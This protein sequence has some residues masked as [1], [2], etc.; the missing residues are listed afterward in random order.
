MKLEEFRNMT[1]EE[2]DDARRNGTLILDEKELLS[3]SES[4]LFE[5]FARVMEIEN[6]EGF[7]NGQYEAVTAILKGKECFCIMPTGSGK[8]ECFQF[9]ALVREGITVVIE[10]IIALMD[11]QIRRIGKSATRLSNIPT[12]EKDIQKL[13]SGCKF[14]Y[15]SPETLLTPKFIMLAEQLNI[16]ML[17]VD[18]AHCVSL[19]GNG[20]R[21]KFMMISRAFRQLKH[22]PQVVAFTATATEFVKDQVK[23]VLSMRKDRVFELNSSSDPKKPFKRDNIELC[24]KSIPKLKYED[25]LERHLGI[26]EENPHFTVI[27]FLKCHPELGKLFSA[28]KHIF[29]TFEAPTP[30]RESFTTGNDDYDKLIREWSRELNP[31]KAK[32]QRDK[33]LRDKR[34]EVRKLLIEIKMN[35]KYPFLL[36]DIL[37]ADS[38]AK[39]IGSDKPAAVIVYCSTIA[40]TNKL[41][42]RLRTDP[43]IK[44]AK[45]TPCIYHGM[46]EHEQRKREQKYF[47]EDDRCRLMVATKA[48]GIGVDKGNVRLVVHFGIPRCIE[49]Y[50]QEAGRGGRDRLPS[51]AVLYDYEPDIEDM[52]DAILNEIIEERPTDR[53]SFDK[54]K[55]FAD[56]MTEAERK[57]IR[58]LIEWRKK[59]SKKFR[60]KKSAAEM[61]VSRALALYG[62]K[63]SRLLN[64]IN[65][66]RY[67]KLVSYLFFGGNTPEERREYIA[68]YLAYDRLDLD[69][70]QIEDTNKRIR[71][72]AKWPEGLTICT[73]KAAYELRDGDYEPGLPHICKEGSGGESVFFISERVDFLD[74]MIANAVFSLGFGG[75]TSI[76]VKKIFILLTGDPGAA[77]EPD[78][79]KALIERIKRLMNVKMDISAG[80]VSVYGSFLELEQKSDTIF[81]YLGPGALCGFSQ[82]YKQQFITIPFEELRTGFTATA[83]DGSERSVKTVGDSFDNIK[84]KLMLAWRLH[85]IAPDPNKQRSYNQNVIRIISNDKRRKGLIELLDLSPG[86]RFQDILHRI[87]NH[88]VRLG[89]L[90]PD[91]E[92][93]EEHIK[94]RSAQLKT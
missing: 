51:R 42:N 14:I 76:T 30:M 44:A 54:L 15:I 56:R 74:I 59:T 50:F 40:E 89:L 64:A 85:M 73:C 27:K 39:S 45:I 61:T 55:S 67:K 84:L 80:E 68:H 4:E 81:N 7:N 26:T 2:V 20:F 31:A 17:V 16:R 53:M 32:F 49:D 13:K 24:V 93:T 11:D 65:Y 87:L 46:M 86:P 70:K 3:L 25:A 79:R 19:W 66:V 62:L 47:M 9:P 10:P 75:M 72:E 58:E 60:A 18:E 8:S 1:D 22:R 94:W 12:L 83:A 92:L 52:G 63:D 57:A 28:Y 48:F 29:I 82:K 91:Y 90:E 23:T 35:E 5:V 71:H 88:Y 33:A 41:Y 6:G 34:E 21:P 77:P 78:V 43:K 38:Y 69:D 36:E 37:S